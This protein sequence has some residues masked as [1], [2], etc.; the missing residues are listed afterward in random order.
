MKTGHETL[1]TIYVRLFRHEKPVDRRPPLRQLLATLLVLC[2]GL[3]ANPG[4]A[5]QLEGPVRIGI[6]HPP[7]E[8][9][10]PLKAA[11]ARSANEGAI[12]AEEE[13][14]F[15]ASMFGFDFAVVQRE[16]EGEAV[17]AAAQ[18]LIASED[19]FALA[20]GFDGEE[21]RLL[22]Q[23][24]QDNAIPFI[25]LIAADDALRN[26][27][28]RP[29]TFHMSPSAA[30]YLDALAGWYVRAGFRNWFTIVGDTDA[31]AAQHE[32]MLW[33]LNERHFGAREVGSATMASGG[34]IDMSTIDQIEST[35]ADLV[36]LLVSAQDQLS[37]LA[38]LEEAG[39]EAMVTGFPDPL[40]QTREFFAQSSQAAPNLGS[41]MRAIAWEPTLDA[42]GAREL[43]ARYQQ[44]WEKPMEQAAWATYQSV[45]AFFEAA[46]FTG[47]TEADDVF[48]HLTAPTSVFDVWKGIGTSFRPWDHQL[49]QPLYLIDIDPAATEPRLA[50]QLVGELPAI[51][52]PGTDPIERL[53]Q[54]GDLAAQ[55]SCQF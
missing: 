42:Y 10:D 6:I 26:D 35:G 38:A 47:S 17:T 4:L 51:Y 3:V 11:V 18:D 28:C 53:D 13:F 46:M 8:Q 24:A 7:V 1:E 48:A 23:W 50:G 43:N 12:M 16:A 14:G 29:S 9:S 33:G 37:A 36:V 5:Q 55:S 32:R 2:V 27:L 45:K 25:N 34:A 40:A 19:I 22:S 39:L 41:A 30:M 49:R 15:N 54:L 31:A 20:G 21:A 52:M 44:R